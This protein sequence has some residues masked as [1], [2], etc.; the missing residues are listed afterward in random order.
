MQPAAA[1]HLYIQEKLVT[2]RN[3]FSVQLNFVQY[4]YYWIIYEILEN[5]EGT[6]WSRD[7]DIKW[8][9]FESELDQLGAI[10]SSESSY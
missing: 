6:C 10:L 8:Q 2:S 5:T 1:T 9:Q 7:N 3:F 4:D